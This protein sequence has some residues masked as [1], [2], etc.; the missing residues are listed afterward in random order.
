MYNVVQSSA[1]LTMRSTCNTIQPLAVFFRFLI[2]IS[3]F[4][5]FADT[6]PIFIWTFW[7]VSKIL[8]MENTILP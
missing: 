4:Q 6:F 7:F 2:Y 5:L 8:S 1:Q 3:I